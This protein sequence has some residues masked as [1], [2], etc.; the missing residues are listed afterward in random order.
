[1]ESTIEKTN[2]ETKQ[3]VSKEMLEKFEARKN[4]LEK[5]EKKLEEKIKEKE[6]KLYVIDGKLDT[7]NL[8]LNYVRK[9]AEWSFHESIGIIELE[10]Q[11]EL[12]R[13]KLTSGKVKELMLDSVALEAIYYF[14]S[15]YKGKGI[16]DAKKFY[17]KHLKPVGEAM[18][19]SNQDKEELNLLRKDVASLREA[20]NVGPG[21]NLSEDYEKVVEEILKEIEEK[22]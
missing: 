21:V 9:E 2:Q 13:K 22:K 14:L 20:V 15:K 8:L 12:S 19:R 1:M 18:T 11:L 5:L 4:A 7:C 17:E 10:R 16:E 6:K 3:E